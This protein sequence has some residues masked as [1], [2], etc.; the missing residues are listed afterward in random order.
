[1]TSPQDRRAPVHNQRWIEL[2]NVGSSSIPAFGAVEITDSYRPES[3]ELETPDGGPTV[4]KVRLATVDN[5]CAYCLNGAQT[6]PVGERRRLGTMDSPAL[7]LLSPTPTALQEYGIKAGSYY[8]QQDTDCPLYGFILLGDYDATTD[9]GRVQF[10]PV[11]TQPTWAVAT[12]DENMCPTDSE[13]QIQS[14]TA[15]GGRC[16]ITVNQPSY[17]NNPHGFVQCDGGEV[18]LMP[19]GCDWVVVGAPP[20]ELTMLKD[21]TYADCTL[22]GTYGTFYGYSCQTNCSTLNTTSTI[23]TGCQEY[24]L[25]GLDTESTTDGSGNVN[26][27]GI[28]A[29]V[30]QVCVWECDTS[31]SN[32]DLIAFSNVK[33]LIDLTWSN[34]D[35][36]G[37]FK[38]HW[39]LCVQAETTDT[40]ITAVDCSTGST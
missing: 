24:V 5:P 37:T 31:E 19:D 12:L 23:M 10:H 1:M 15:K 29:K 38:E 32:G 18:I 40:L 2:E 17:V 22:D 25:V 7:A 20:Q 34:P 33:P 13:V 26:S 21:L 3:S 35:I 16:G 8:L 39:A 36:D 28:R 11:N 30:K 14:F 27:C 6:I 9:V 4:L